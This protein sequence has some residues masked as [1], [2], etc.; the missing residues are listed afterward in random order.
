MGIVS[1]PVKLDVI[2]EKYGIK[3]FVETGTGPGISMNI[4]VKSNLFEK[5]YGVEL[6]ED[7]FNEAINKFPNVKMYQGFSKDVMYDVL[8]DLD[9]SPTFFWLDA[10]FPGADY[11][12]QKYDAEKDDSIRIP[13]ESELKI[14]SENRDCSKDVFLM[15]DLRIYKDAPFTA[16][17]WE[18][19]RTAGAKN[20][21]FME[22]LIGKT[23]ILIENHNDQGYM[24]GY[25]VNSD[26]ETI[27]STIRFDHPKDNSEISEFI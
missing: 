20:C 2:V 10:H 25:P 19:R 24:T 3:N 16:G 18:D 8:K 26:E 23:H 21:D 12:G 1:Y 11:R 22:V 15:D 27:K 9:D 5:L 17:V 6:D 13:L 4:A 14:I 7:W